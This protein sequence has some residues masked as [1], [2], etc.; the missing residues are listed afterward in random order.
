M[1]RELTY[2]YIVAGAGSA[3]CALARGLCDR[4]ELRVLLIE[5][6]PPAEKFWVHTPAGMAK[7]YFNRTLN[8][9]YH[10]E[11]L[12]R[13]HQ[14]RMYWPRGKA[15]GGSSAINGMIYIRGHRDDFD[16]WRDLGNPG[17]GYDDVLPVFK[18]IEHNE[19]GADTYRAQ[20]GP[21]WI[22]D[23]AER[24]PSCGDFIA[25][26]E[27]VGIPR[28][29]DLNGAVHDGVGY[30]QHTIRD[31]RRQSAY[32]AFI[33]P[34]RDRANLEVLTDCRVE[35]IRFTGR[36]ATGVEAVRGGERLILNA[37]REVILS[38]G[39]LNSPQLL[40]L[41]G[42]GP[43][44]ES[45][46]HGIE[47]RVD[48]PGVGA[49]LQDHF[50]I[51]CGYRATPDS[52]YNQH[53]SGLRKY[54]QGLRYLLTRRGYLALGSSQVA[55]FV[56]S[57]PQEPYADLQISFRPMSFAYHA[58][59]QVHVDRF[60]GMGVS[61]YLLRPRRAGR[62]TLRSP[63]PTH[64]PIMNPDYL[65][66]PEDVRVMTAGIRTIRRIMAAEPIASRVVA[67][68]VPGPDVQSDEQI[69]E[70]MRATGNSAHHQ[71]GTCKMG[72][73]ALAVVDERLRVRGVARL[74]VA[75]AS[76][77]PFLTAG[78]TNAPTIMIGA[79]AA[80]MILEDA[81]STRTHAV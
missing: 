41:S 28:T 48:L 20:G 67:E 68:E 39:S 23:P 53:I 5:A 3:G 78:N 18:R 44:A 34:V 61:V 37:T 33:Q 26:A 56:K 77:M 50:Y 24:V 15:L 73:D 65:V 60:P 35:R 52:S 7:L 71:G 9:N 51:H 40:M 11:P 10:T 22:S 79:K 70:F 63:D 72:R 8:W 47:V 69:L 29:G 27:R 55:A 45:Q 2:D 62:V 64:S 59:G 81:A 1:N 66:D 6:G 54:W 49:N 58:S 30:M 14:R 42:I 19:R 36:E 21:L 13:L 38:C 12:P 57:R 46:R 32:V 31:G 4:P 80:E 76:I 75:D 25:S 17:W 74:R 43:G 16:G